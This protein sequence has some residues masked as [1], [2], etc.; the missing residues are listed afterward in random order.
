MLGLSKES[1]QEDLNDTAIMQD[2]ASMAE[3]K[4]VERGTVQA[5]ALAKWR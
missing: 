5:I 4:R 2:A 3:H 1:G